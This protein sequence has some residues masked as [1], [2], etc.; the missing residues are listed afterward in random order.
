[1]AKVFWTK[2][3]LA[4]LGRIYEYL[5]RSSRSFDL[6]ERICVELLAAANDRLQLLPDAGSPVDVASRYGA[7]EI[8]KH[9]YRII[10]VHQGEACFVVRCLHSSRDIVEQLDPENWIDDVSKYKPE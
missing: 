7:R 10:Y 6:A 2:S 5:A 8:Y 4:D 3:G 9:S 1:M